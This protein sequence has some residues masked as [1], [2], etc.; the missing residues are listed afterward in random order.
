MELNLPSYKDHINSSI[1]VST[2]WLADASQFQV[3]ENLLRDI[4]NTFQNH[5]KIIA[6]GNGG[7]ATEAS[8]LVGE[9]VGKCK[10]DNGPWPAICLNDSTTLLT[11]ISN[12]WNFE[13]IFERQLQAL[14]QPNDIVIGFTTSGNSKN[15]LTALEYCNNSGNTTSLW[16]SKK[17]PESNLIGKHNIVAPTFETTFSQELHLQLIHV[18]SLALESRIS[19]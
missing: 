7:S 16:T 2:D 1:K 17:C 19:K 18:I 12:D 11:C 3:L 8:H 14:L 10:T 4:E 5:G 9:I 13:F 6:F 15:V